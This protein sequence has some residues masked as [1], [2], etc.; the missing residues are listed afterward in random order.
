MKK[1]LLL[2]LVTGLF[3]GAACTMTDTQQEK[4]LEQKEIV[5]IGFV[6]HL[7]GEYA[8]YSIPMKQATE[9]AIVDANK[10]STQYTYELIAEDDTGDKVKAASAV[11]KLIDIEKV[12]YIISAQGS[13]AT[14]AIT[15]ITEGN[16]KILMI[17]L[18]SAPELNN[19]NNYIFRSVPSD[20]YQSTKMIEEIKKLGEKRVAMLYLNDAYGAGIYNVLANSNEIE[21]VIAEKFEDLATDVKTQLAKIKQ[22]QPDILVV[23]AH[24]EFPTILKQTEELGLNAK[25]M[26][27]E[28]FKD[29]DLLAQTKEYAEGLLVP[30]IGDQ[31][32]YINFA[33]RYKN[34]FGEEPSAYAPYAYDGTKALIDAIEQT[35]N[36]KGAIKYILYDT[37]FQGASGNVSF[38]MF[39]ERVGATYDM[40]KVKNGV[41][42][43]T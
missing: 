40:Y 43:K 17:T 42:E 37:S 14:A 7:S 34:E 4:N 9:L 5:E 38:D 36:N 28:T 39:G 20:A 15:P 3:T 23:V 33:T 21:I 18:A 2:L 16:K 12:D 24:N 11:K 13:G 35:D 22:A 25:V 41:F 29:A 10:K 32:D 31:T 27:S 19:T 26:A 6:G 30:S 1:I 8:N